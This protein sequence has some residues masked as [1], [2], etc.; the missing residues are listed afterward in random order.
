MLCDS[1]SVTSQKTQNYGDSS[2]IPGCQGF[3]KGRG[4]AE[5]EEHRFSGQGNCV[6][7]A[8]W[9][10]DF[11]HLSRPLKCRAGSEP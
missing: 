2:E 7:R 5:Q 8:W 9:M 4:R 10:Q 3:R 11:V 6:E 1:N